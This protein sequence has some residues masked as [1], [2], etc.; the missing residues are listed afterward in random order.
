MVQ[1]WVKSRVLLPA[2]LATGFLIVS[3][4][5]IASTPESKRRKAEYVAP[6]VEVMDVKE[7][8]H[9]VMVRA[10]GLV[11]AAGQEVALKPQVGGRIETV[12]PNFRPGALIPAGQTILQIEKADHE[13]ALSEAAARLARAKASV[14][15]EKGQQQIAREEYE[16]LGD[17]FDFDENSRALALRVPQL[18]QFEAE[19]AIAQSS[20]ERAKLALART[21]VTLPYDALVLDTA[22]AVGEIVSVGSNL[23]AFA[24]AD[25]FWVELRVQQKYLSRLRARS[26]DSAGSLV[27]IK[28]NGL[29]YEG[30]LV[31]LRANLVASTRMGGAIVEVRNSI[32]PSDKP[33]LLIGSHVAAEIAAGSI[34]GA[35]EVPRAAL[36]DNA[37]LYVVDGEQRLQN[38]QATV[39]WELPESVI[40]KSD[41]EARD[42]LVVSRVSGVAP[43]TEV[44]TRYQSKKSVN[45]AT[46]TDEINGR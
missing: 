39:L 34:D 25:K 36:L 46:L 21:R 42:T 8:S 19:E 14:A 17:D 30:E 12:H 7:S 11:G 22:A 13:I 16:L 35:I 6:L 27:T 4:A 33:S 31:G 40:I 3:Y 18:K 28:S 38:R 26:S 29:T 45:N 24:Q 20:Y 1:K 2:M 23:G 43:G 9:N 5:L 15:L 37:L 44:R 10:Q 41:L 32:A